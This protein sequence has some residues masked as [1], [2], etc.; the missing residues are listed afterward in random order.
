M[1]APLQVNRVYPQ[2]QAGEMGGCLTELCRRPGPSGDSSL[3]VCLGCGRGPQGPQRRAPES[4]LA[5]C[6]AV[7]SASAL[8]SFPPTYRAWSPPR[9][10]AQAHSPSL[11]PPLRVAAE[12]PGLASVTASSPR[13]HCLP[14]PRAKAFWKPL[15][16]PVLVS[17][18]VLGPDPGLLLLGILRQLPW[19]GPEISGLRVLTHP[20][21]AVRSLR[22]LQLGAASMP[23]AAPLLYKAPSSIIL[24]CPRRLSSAASC[25][26]SRTPVSQW[27]TADA[28][29]RRGPVEAAWPLR[30]RRGSLPSGPAPPLSPAPRSPQPGLTNGPLWCAQLSLLHGQ[31]D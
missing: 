28:G 6:T 13:P 14:S 22:P 26:R 2:P 8:F 12:R 17:T 3:T 18:S 1:G 24:T 30:V 10:R 15:Y 11:A 7:V 29:G 31:K 9:T 19:E 4:H 23:P 20:G 16:V 27:H 21:C 25:G 5:V